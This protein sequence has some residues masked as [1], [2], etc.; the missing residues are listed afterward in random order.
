MNSGRGIPASLLV[1]NVAIQIRG[2][3]YGLRLVHTVYVVE[4]NIPG[5]LFS[6]S[7]DVARGAMARQIPAAA[8]G[9]FAARV[10][11]PSG[12]LECVIAVCLAACSNVRYGLRT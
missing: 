1:S 12:V 5:F 7:I 6:C 8:A 2:I 11:V 4:G 3:S 9:S 10:A